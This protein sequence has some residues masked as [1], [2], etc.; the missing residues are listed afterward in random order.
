MLY[1]GNAATLKSGRTPIATA[2]RAERKGAT[3][4]KRGGL[5]PGGEDN[6]HNEWEESQERR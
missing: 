1:S 6:V 4:R 3:P 5:A 2:E